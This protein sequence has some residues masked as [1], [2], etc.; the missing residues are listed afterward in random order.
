MRLIITLCLLAAATFVG[1]PLVTRSKL[2]PRTIV[3]PVGGDLQA[4]INRAVR[5]DTIVLQVGTYN[6]STPDTGF[7]LPAKAG[8]FN[9]SNYITIQTANLNSLPS[10]RVSPADL[11]NMPSLV[12]M[13]RGTPVITVAG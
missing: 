1:L 12:V 6:T 2:Q 3:V 5:G 9:G 10:A 11:A 8:T 13:R 7:L 4:A